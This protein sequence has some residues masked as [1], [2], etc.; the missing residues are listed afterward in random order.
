MVEECDRPRP[1][2][3][4]YCELHYNRWKNNGDPLV[5]NK[6]GTKKKF[7]KCQYEDCET[8][9]HLARGYCR[10]H[11]AR[12]R[13]TGS[14]EILDKEKPE[15]IRRQ[16]DSSKGYIRLVFKD[17]S[18]QY[19]HRY[20]MEQHLG[21]KL[22]SGENVHHINGVRNDNRI[23]NLELWSTSQPAGQRIEDKVRWAREILKM[24]GD[25]IND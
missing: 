6:G 23:E 18:T 14:L 19:E 24:Y 11:Y 5:V 25:C 21:R 7:K 12:L 3:H 10:K 20:I 4:G 2:R 8:D 22:L 15:F 9:H 16:Q 1:Y 17:G 13:R